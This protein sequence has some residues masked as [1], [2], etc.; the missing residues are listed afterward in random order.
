MTWKILGAVS[1]AMVA[2]AS[3][4][5][6][7][8]GGWATWTD[9]THQLTF[10]YPVGWTVRQQESQIEGAVRVFAGAG[11]YECQVWSLPHPASASAPA[12]AVRERYTPPISDSAWSEIAGGL[13]DFRNRLT[14]RQDGVDTSGSWP[15]Q[16]VSL[17]AGDHHG[18]GTIQGRPGREL[19]SICQSYDNQDRTETFAAIE[20]SIGVPGD[21]TTTTPP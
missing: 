14:I 3:A 11:D 19:I 12:A 15:I 10:R 16:H 5:V 9:P 17:V 20:K 7:Q 8:D 13:P 2:L 6:A 1:L 18:R 21:Q 4:A